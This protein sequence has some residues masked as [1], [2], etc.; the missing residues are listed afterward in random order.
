MHSAVQFNQIEIAQTLINL[1][2]DI[3]C[4]KVIKETPLIFAA[5][6][7]NSSM[8][9]ILIGKGA[10]KDAQDKWNRTS[11]H[12][13]NSK[14]HAEVVRILLECGASQNIKN[15]EGDRVL[16]S[17]LKDKKFN[18]FKTIMYH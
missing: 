18:I 13:A 10:N 4:Q 8:C 5:R 7:G 1:G 14:D 17:S 15:N 3:E 11:L 16:E 9:E 6:R 12:R 2:A